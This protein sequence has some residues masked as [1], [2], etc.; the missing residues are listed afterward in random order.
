MTEYSFLQFPAD[1][2]QVDPKIVDTLPGSAR[3]VLD[4]VRERGPLTHNEL[5]LATGLPPRTIRYAVRRLKDHGILESLSSLRDCRTCY[6]FVSRRHIRPEA[7]EDARSRA[8]EASRQGRLVER[9]QEGPRRPTFAHVGP[10]PMAPAF[11]PAYP[12]AAAVTPA[13]LATI[14]P[15]PAA[16]TVPAAPA[17]PLAAEAVDQ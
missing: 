4:A 13:P 12:S 1:A 16:P 2:I 7:L 15:A 11:A 14:A 5:G 10:R 3:R 17:D 9:V 8:D 6:F